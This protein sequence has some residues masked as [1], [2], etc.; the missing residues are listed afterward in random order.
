MKMSDVLRQLRQEQT[1]FVGA[2]P[3]LIDRFEAFLPVSEDTPRLTL[4]EGFTPLVH[5]KTLGRA[6]GCPLLH[7]KLEGSNPTGSFKDRGMVV[8]VAKALE[9]GAQAIVCASTGNTSASAAAYGASA[10]LDVIVVLPV[11]QIAAGKLVQAQIA[12][13]RVIAVDGNFDAA[14]RI[15]RDLVE[16]QDPA[17]PVTLVN[18]VNPHRLAGQKTGAFEVCEDLGG[19]PDYLAIPV[20]NAGNISA[21][22]QGFLDYRAAGLVETVP[23]M[24]GFQA[25]GAAPLVTGRTVLEPETVATAI[26]IGS[27]ASAALALRARDDSGGRIEAVTDQ[28]I[29]DAYRDLAR[30][31]G[32][33]CEPASAAS[34]AGVRKLS[35]MGVI[36]PGATIV[37]V[38]TGHGLKDPDL[39]SR[40]AGPIIRAEPTLAGVR[41][42]LGW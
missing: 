28:E 2:R 17:H 21:Y 34:V 8:A 18:S 26:R 1:K 36:D 32:V 27:P 29:L 25:A 33:F 12:G 19:A 3:R 15:V 9:D 4:G 20:G 38:L 14:L 23:V 30:Y 24:L 37:C 5:A 41:Q 13:A 40:E 35:A 10:G 39:A 22:W 16:R 7:L 6:M 11:G 42:A 31:E